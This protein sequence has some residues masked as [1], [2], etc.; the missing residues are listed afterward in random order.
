MVTA[1]L[2]AVVQTLAAASGVDRSVEYTCPGLEDFE[3]RVVHHVDSGGGTIRSKGTGGSIAIG[4]GTMQ[5]ELAPRRRPSGF[6]WYKS[7]RV[8][9]A[10]VTYGLAVDADTVTNGQH[11]K[12]PQL[13]ATIL[14]AP[15]SSTVNLAADPN[16]ENT[17]LKVARTLATSRCASVG[18]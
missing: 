14:G 9:A 3:I 16:D 4:I 1:F 6:R 18:K 17:F 12:R 10:T 15:I 13:Q 11:V 8:G 5:E 2:F 7:E